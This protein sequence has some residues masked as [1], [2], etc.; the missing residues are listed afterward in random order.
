MLH[1]VAGNVLHSIATIV[2]IVAKYQHMFVL[3]IGFTGSRVRRSE[4][5]S[6]VDHLS[7]SV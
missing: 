7:Y 6:A 4:E 3:Q 1:A 2:T 5:A